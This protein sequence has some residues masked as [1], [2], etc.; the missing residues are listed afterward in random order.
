MWVFWIVVFIIELVIYLRSKSNNSI[1]TNDP[2][3]TYRDF[4]GRLR[5]RISH[6]LCYV[7]SIDGEKRLFSIVDG[8]QIRNY[9]RE[10]A[11]E[12][13]RSKGNTVGVMSFGKMPF[14]SSKERMFVPISCTRYVDIKTHELYC[15]VR[16]CSKLFYMDQNGY[17]VR[18]T[19][20]QIRHNRNH[21]DD[22]MFLVHKFNRYAKKQK[23]CNY[24]L[25]IQNKDLGDE[26]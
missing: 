8:R 7:L 26:I 23:I 2:L 21:V 13:G 25:M 5:H 9:T 19:D 3:D 1:P 14:N 22:G 11:I 10:Y 6:E 12:E 24:N 15:I 20:G 4:R 17:L 16:Y 18:E